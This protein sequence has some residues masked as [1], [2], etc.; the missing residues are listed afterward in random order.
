MSL[1]EAAIRRRADEHGRWT[2][3]SLPEGVSKWVPFLLQR[4]WRSEMDLRTVAAG[5]IRSFFVDA[6][7]ALLASSAPEGEVGLLG[8][9]EG[10][11]QT[12]FT[13]MMPTPVPAM[14]G[15]RIRAVVCTEDCNLP[16]SEAGQV[17]A[18][19]RHVQHEENIPWNKW[20]PPVPAVMAELRMHRVRQVAAGEYHC[21]AVT[22]DGVLFTWETRDEDGVEPD[23]P[24]PELGLGRFA[25]LLGLPHRVVAFEGVRIT[26]VAVGTGFTVA[27]TE[28][29]AIYSFGMGDGRLGHGKGDDDVGIYLPKRIEALDGVHVVTVAAGDRHTLALTRCGRV[30]PWGGDGPHNPVHGLG[31]RK[32]S[33]VGVDWGEGDNYVPQLMTVLV[34]KR[35]RAIAAGPDMACAVT[36]AGAPYTWGINDSG[37]LGHGDVRR[38][39]RPRRVRALEGIRVVGVSIHDQHTLALAA[40]G[41]VYS[42]GEGPGLGVSRGDEGGSDGHGRML[43]PQRILN[44]KCMVPR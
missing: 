22:E 18:W 33:G 37:N 28:A 21:A 15:V 5:R 29:G 9:Q 6:N 38:R 43:T 44:L 24:V 25:H 3:S 35:V 12:S 10:S 27:V 42:F 7:G 26:S 36:D 13:A 40:D 19:G 20:Q 11:S 41:S 1:V 2:P 17:F 23:E 14:V 4:E 30:F 31:K 39:Y 34:G 8:L 16:L 32:N